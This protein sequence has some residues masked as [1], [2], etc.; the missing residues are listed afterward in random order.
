[1][2]TSNNDRKNWQEFEVLTGSPD[3][4]GKREERIDGEHSGQPPGGNDSEGRGNREY[5]QRSHK[6]CGNQVPNGRGKP[7]LPNDTYLPVPILHILA[8]KILQRI[9]GLIPASDSGRLPD[10]STCPYEAKVE[11][12]I[13]VPDQFL[14]KKTDSLEDVATPTAEID[15]IYRPFIIGIVT[16]RAADRERR[17][18][19][20]CNSLAHIP[21]PAGNPG[22]SYI[23]GLRLT[24]NVHTLLNVVRRIL[25]VSVHPYDNFAARVT[26]G[27]V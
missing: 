2:V 7:M 15:C 5:H 19:G 14:V 26:N 17:L 9:P 23:V 24:K 12:I 8:E 27:S 22:P 13:L 18:K 20:S 11:L 10:F 1:M 6:T 3:G 16:P 4:G 25:R 21:R